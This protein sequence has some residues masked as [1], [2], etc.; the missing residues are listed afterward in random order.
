MVATPSTDT[1]LEKP[2]QVVPEPDATISPGKA[3]PGQTGQDDETEYPSGLKVVLIIVS[4]CLSVF[5]VALDQTIIAPALGAITDQFHSV[6]DIV[7]P[8]QH[9]SPAPPDDR[10][11]H[12]LSLVLGLE[13]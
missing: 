6:K 1:E 8:S 7:S 3:A 13:S 4:L 9:V 12:G 10:V 5:L 2:P 11:I